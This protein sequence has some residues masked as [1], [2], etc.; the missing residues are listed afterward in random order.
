MSWDPL[1]IARLRD[2]AGRGASIRVMVDE[3]RSHY[4]GIDRIA[5]EVDRYLTKA[6]FLRL[7]DVR[8]VEASACLGGGAYSD[9]QINDL[10]LPLIAS[11]RHL[12]SGSGEAGPHATNGMIAHGVPDRGAIDPGKLAQEPA[13]PKS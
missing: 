7:R 1:L 11:T 2:L 3:I 9:E 13:A 10:L 8:N 6:F 5:L 4:P 12:W